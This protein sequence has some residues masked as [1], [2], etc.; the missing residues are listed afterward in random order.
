MHGEFRSAA[1]AAVVRKCRVYAVKLQA[2]EH[3]PAEK[4]QP[5]GTASEAAEK[6]GFESGQDFKSGRKPMRIRRALQ[7]A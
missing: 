7:S 5:T 3:R 2:P 6:L 1:C 4:S